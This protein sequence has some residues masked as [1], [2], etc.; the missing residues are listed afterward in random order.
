MGRLE[1]LGGM[2][3]DLCVCVCICVCRDIDTHVCVL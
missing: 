3:L 1:L 2:F